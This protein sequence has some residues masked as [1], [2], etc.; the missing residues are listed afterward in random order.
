LVLAT[1]ATD[2]LLRFKSHPVAITSLIDWSTS[3]DI[4]SYSD[5][6]TVVP[7]IKNK[8]AKVQTERSEA[9]DYGGYEECFL[10]EMPDR[11]ICS[12]CTKALRDPHLMACC[13]QKYCISCLN[14]WFT[15]QGE[16]QCPHC[17]ATAHGSGYAV[18][19]ILD[20]G[21][22]S[23]IESQF[24]LCSNY[25]EGCEWVGELRNLTSHVPTCGYFRVRC[26]KGCRESKDIL[27]KDVESHLENSCEL[28]GMQCPHCAAR[29]TVRSYPCHE[30]VCEVLH[31]PAQRSR[32]KRNK[33]SCTIS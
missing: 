12:I 22:K 6:A 2:F 19:H 28:R 21:V 7:T 10:E 11:L 24:V 18:L 29:C 20:K 5:V 1:L 26:P 3:E 13:G 32:L 16:K 9:S 14:S 23:E 33:K 8:M 25:K 15:Q 31:P 4:K 17:R 30:K 27:R